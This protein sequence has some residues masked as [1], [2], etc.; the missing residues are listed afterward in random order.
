[1]RSAPSMT[2]EGRP[3]AWW[4]WTSPDEQAAPVEIASLERTLATTALLGISGIDMWN[5]LGGVVF[6][7]ITKL[8]IFSK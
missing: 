8:G 2:S 3:K 4:I 1:M 7:L 5:C 6:P